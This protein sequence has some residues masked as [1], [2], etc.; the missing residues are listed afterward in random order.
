MISCLQFYCKFSQDKDELGELCI[1]F[2]MMVWLYIEL[3]T[4]IYLYTINLW[5]DAYKH[6]VCLVV[7]NENAT[8]MLSNVEKK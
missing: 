4:E 3:F 6:F 2:S 5:N 1:L 7:Q 8:I